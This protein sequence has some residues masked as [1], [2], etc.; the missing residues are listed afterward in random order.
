MTWS[1]QYVTEV[2]RELYPVKCKDALD[3]YES[4]AF[5]EFTYLIV[6]I[7]ERYCILLVKIPQVGNEIADAK[8]ISP[9][10]ARMI[11]FIFLPNLRQKK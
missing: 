11:F 9:L 6:K 1:N 2:R 5:Q 4:S 7:M 3:F 10:S 8:L